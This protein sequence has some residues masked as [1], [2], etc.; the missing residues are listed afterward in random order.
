MVRPAIQHRKGRALTCREVDL[1]RALDARGMIF[2]FLSLS[3]ILH[4][5]SSRQRRRNE[6]FSETVNPGKV[7]VSGIRT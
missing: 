1:P 4:G 7:E 6:R 2:M 3:T 5:A